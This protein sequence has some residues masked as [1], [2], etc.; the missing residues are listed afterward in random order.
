[1]ILSA[2]PNCVLLETNLICLHST[3]GGLLGLEH[4]NVPGSVLRVEHSRVNLFDGQLKSLRVAFSLSVN[5]RGGQLLLQS[6]SL[7]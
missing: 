5:R 2:E 4:S 1:M 7:S 3:R 6:S